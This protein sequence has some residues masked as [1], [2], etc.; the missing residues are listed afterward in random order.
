MIERV[1][2]GRV[3]AASGV[4]ED[5]WIAISAGT[6]VAIGAGGA[7][8]AF[9]T[10]DFGAAWLLPGA[11][12]GQT[13]AGSQIGFAGIGPT[14]KAAV[15]GGVTT[16]VDMPYDHPIPVTTASVLREKVAAIGQHAVCDVALYGTIP[17]KPDLSDIRALIEQGVCAFKISSFEAHPDRF[18][19]IDNSATLVLLKALE[20]TGLPLGLHNEDQEI[21]AHATKVLKEEG[22]TG[23]EYHSQSRPPVAEL[24]ATSTFFEVAAA[25]EAHAHIVHISVPEGFE[26]ARAYR[27]R[28]V[29]A[30][31]E[32]CVHYLLFDAETDMPRLKGLLKVN[33][34]IRPGQADA[35]WDVLDKGLCSFVSSD[36]SAWPLE[37]KTSASIFDVAAGM[38]GLEAMVPAFF[39]AAA[40]RKDDVRAAMLTAEYLSDRPARF[41]GLSR[42]GRIAPGFDADIAVLTPEEFIYDATANPDGPGWSAYGGMTFAVRH[43]ATFVRGRKVW[44]GVSVAAAAGHGRY[45][46]RRN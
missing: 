44:D 5:G 19:R 36:H 14:T 1:L 26:M 29:V 31:A 41:F 20:S 12:D 32:M 4:I 42:K 17:P 23:A 33:P 10:Q 21:V 8:E 16:I 24:A 46:P 37:R 43:S 27:E 40:R 9:D 39:T 35:L 45:V 15:I 6:I 22:K 13:H 11:V 30:T 3:V 7:P 34:P 38:P 18:P 25:T 2:K 28:G